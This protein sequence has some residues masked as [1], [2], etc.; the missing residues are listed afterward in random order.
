[1]IVL[2]DSS[3]A[4]NDEPIDPDQMLVPQNLLKVLHAPEVHSE[5]KLEPK[6][7]QSLEKFFE[8]VDGLW[9][10]SR[11]LPEEKQHALI[12]QLEQ[13]AWTWAQKQ[14]GQAATK[15][16]QQIVY[17]SQGVRMLLDRKVMDALALQEEQ[18]SKFRQAALDVHKAQQSLQQKMATG[19]EVSDEQK[20]LGQ[21]I[22]RENQQVASVLT[23]A[24]LTKV[25][26]LRGQ[27]FDTQKLQ[28]IHP[29]APELIP[30]SH[31]INS[32]PLK[33]SELRGKV[34]LVHFY[35]FQCHNC[36][37]N[38]HIYNRWHEQYK[39]R[40]VIVLGI[41]TPETASES[42]VNKVKEAAREREFEFPVLIDLEKKNW[43][44][45]SN[46]MWPTVYVIDQK[47]YLRHW[48]QGELNWQ[49]AT[50][51]QQIEKIVDELLKSAENS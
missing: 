38:F 47:G 15:R 18:V 6:H 11:N 2:V 45:W 8:E 35:A 16:L 7:I 48:W 39:D 33:L 26:E 31:W 19:G 22:E 21:A 3:H 40:G 10:R 37:A 34:V 43:N 1:M 29:M 13:R 4:Q 32:Q 46:T 5:L 28:R 36:H 20:L 9:F 25:N 50:A 30:V 12:R 27:D 17:R 51:D 44:A 14:T 23:K 49:G 24:Q 42:D 41:Q